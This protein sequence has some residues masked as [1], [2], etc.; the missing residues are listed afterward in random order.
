[1]TSTKQTINTKYFYKSHYLLKINFLNI[2]KQGKI[3]PPTFDRHL[4][5]PDSENAKLR[6]ISKFL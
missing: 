2:I 5:Q 6:W 4:D 3:P 1:V